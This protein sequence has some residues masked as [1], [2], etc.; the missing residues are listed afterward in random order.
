MD[1]RTQP[2]YLARAKSYMAGGLA[3]LAFVVALAAGT[4][5]APAF[6][7]LSWLMVTAGA[8]GVVYVAGA[9]IAAAVVGAHG[10][11]ARLRPAVVSSRDGRLRSSGR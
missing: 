3:L 7:G 10:P 2:N 11:A 1:A 8:L 6:G 9:T 4:A 5:G